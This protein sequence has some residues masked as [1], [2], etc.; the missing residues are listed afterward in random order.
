PVP[1]SHKQGE[2]VVPAFQVPSSDEKK[3]RD[4]P[5]SSI[6]GTKHGHSSEPGVTDV[7]D[8]LSVDPFSLFVIWQLRQMSPYQRDLAM[9][10]IRQEL[11]EAKYTADPSV[12]VEGS[13]HSSALGGVVASF[14]AAEGQQATKTQQSR[15]ACTGPPQ[16][17]IQTTDV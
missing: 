3:G 14:R 16:S 12:V 11:F 1:A 7:G 13:P 4:S 17:P 5:A 15:T 10:R 8:T 2:D 6:D 9:L